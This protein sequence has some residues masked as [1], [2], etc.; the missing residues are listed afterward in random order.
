MAKRRKN[1]ATGR[2]KQGGKRPLLALLITILLIVLAFYLLEKLPK[3]VQERPG[4][5]PR[6]AERY[7]LPPRVQERSVEH[8]P[9]TTAVA[10]PPPRHPRR[11]RPVGPGTVAII[12]DDMG[13]SM[14]EARELMAIKVPVTFSLIPGLPKVKE[15]AEAAH[16]RGMQV[17]VHMPM[18]P[19]GYP[20]QR[21]EKNGL[22]LS[23]ENEEIKRKVRGYLQGVPYAVGANNHM[24]SQFTEDEEKMG[25]VFSVLK[26]KGLF[27]IDSRTSPKSVGYALARAM[28]VETAAR[29]VFLDNV[30]EVGAIKVQLGELAGLARKRGS[31]I[32]IC[33]P[34]RTT[35][36][37]LAATLPEL[38]REGITFVYVSA[39]VR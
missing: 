25:A 30:Q 13:S 21:M 6:T 2:R 26:E 37:A 23:Q 5:K 11:A 33:H 31:A 14:Q 19:K 4:E 1:S 38:Q 22:L 12:V 28:G 16:G 3:L 29:N 39:L 32:G 35:I 9:Y 34:H 27:F 10:S 8:Q 18:E 20:Q 15:V 24:G 17:M 7:K 36:Q